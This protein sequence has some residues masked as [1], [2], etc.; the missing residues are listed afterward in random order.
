MIRR[1]RSNKRK[2]G[3]GPINYSDI[4]NKL[5]LNYV[6]E[7]LQYCVRQIDNVEI[8]FTFIPL[9]NNKIVTEIYKGLEI[10]EKHRD[11]NESIFDETYKYTNILCHTHPNK[12]ILGNRI[13]NPPSAKD[14]EISYFQ[15]FQYNL[16][17]NFVFSDEG[18]YFYYPT[19]KILEIL[20]LTNYMGFGVSWVPT[21][22]LDDFNNNFEFLNNIHMDCVNGII[23]IKDFLKTINDDGSFYC[24]FRN[25]NDNLV[26]DVPISEKDYEIV[27]VYQLERSNKNIPRILLDKDVIPYKYSY[28]YLTNN[29]KLKSEIKN[30]EFG[31]LF[32]RNK[33]RNDGKSHRR[34]VSSKHRR[35][36]SLLGRKIGI[37]IHEGIYANKEQAVAV[38]YSQVRKRHP[39]CRRI[40]GKKKSKKSK[41]RMF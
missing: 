30:Y 11:I 13:N 2:L 16:R 10:I 15:Y 21:N 8:I 1:N 34:R 6:K 23:N 3:K 19:K 25:W 22:I 20:D 31:K 38:A 24:E 12:T 27:S 18:I 37:N 36:K 5:N 33:K 35:C 40:L 9:K 26:F 28:F 32:S 41:R 29:D 4:S 17:Y 39:S 14:F 7:L